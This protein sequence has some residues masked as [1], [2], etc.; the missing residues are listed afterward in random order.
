[1]WLM[2]RSPEEQN[3]IGRFADGAG[4]EI[5]GWYIEGDGV[6]LSETALSR[7]MADM[8]LRQLHI[9][10]VGFAMSDCVSSMTRFGTPFRSILDGLRGFSETAF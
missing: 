10:G 1:M 6:E 3:A 4:Y 5:G 8:V 9:S 7:L 2:S